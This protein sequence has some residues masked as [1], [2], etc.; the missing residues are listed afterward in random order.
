MHTIYIFDMKSYSKLDK[1]AFRI[2]IK[3]PEKIIYEISQKELQFCRIIIP[4]DDS[5]KDSITLIRKIADDTPYLLTY[6]AQEK[7]GDHIFFPDTREYFIYR[8]SDIVFTLLK[9]A[10]LLYN[11]NLFVA[12]N[13]VT[14][15]TEQFI[16]R[17]SP[18]VRYI[19][20][21]AQDQSGIKELAQRVYDETGLSLLVT[22]EARYI[23]KCTA[24]AI[25]YG[26]EQFAAAQLFHP[27]QIVF[28]FDSKPHTISLFGPMIIDGASY[29]YGKYAVMKDVPV[30]N[31]A[32]YELL[33][34]INILHGTPPKIKGFLY[35]G[36]PYRDNFFIADKNS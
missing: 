9:Q 2:G 35:H 11:M 34:R 19:T 23:K 1:M 15:Q 10:H 22:D 25:F 20:L 14:K 26:M 29:E 7:L 18:K 3:K 21:F 17:L 28:D 16:L 6:A 4:E 36:K 12:V 13:M 30:S 5:T 31:A 33:Y 27:K 8:A 24:A 32:L